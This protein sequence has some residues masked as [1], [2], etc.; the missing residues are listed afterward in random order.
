MD[1][2]Q[3]TKAIL[4]GIN[5][6]IETQKETNRLLSVIDDSGIKRI[7]QG[8]D[9]TIKI[10]SELQ[11]TQKEQLEKFQTI[12]LLTPPKVETGVN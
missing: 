9:D 3:I 8:Q 5:T 2:E 12:S 10:L 7:K 11:E 4:E 1:L 6:M